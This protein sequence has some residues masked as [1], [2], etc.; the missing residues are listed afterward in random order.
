MPCTPESSLAAVGFD[1]ETTGVDEDSIVTVA[2][3]WSPSNGT[4]IHCFH[5][6]DP[7]EV[8]RAL[9]NA[10]Y[11]YTYNGMEFDLPRFAKHCNRSAGAWVRKTVDPLYT[12]KYAMG[13]GACIKLNDV[14]H[15]NG[16]EPKSGSGLQAV[17][18]WHDGNREALRSYCMDDARL[19]YELCNKREGIKWA[20]KWILKLWEARVLDFQTCNA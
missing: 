2:C 9:D 16:Y 3:V 18:F 1:I 7:S 19:T 5:D 11:I 15:E 10:Q 20:K 6:D 12:M 4:Q 8:I 13:L 14:L 17:Q